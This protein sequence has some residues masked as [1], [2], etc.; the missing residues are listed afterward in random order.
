MLPTSGAKCGVSIARLI[1]LNQASIDTQSLERQGEGELSE[2]DLNIHR[3]S[4]APVVVNTTPK[5]LIDI[6]DFTTILPV[7]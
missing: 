6:I 4:A 5:N 7:W 2:G 1:T 3:P